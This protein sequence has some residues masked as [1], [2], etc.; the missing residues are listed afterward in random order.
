MAAG[1]ATLKV[2]DRE[3]AWA[4]LEERGA[5]LEAELKPVLKA[6]PFPASFVRVGSIG[7]FAL[8][9]G[10]PRSAEALDSGTGA[11]FK[12]IFQALLDRGIA[13]APSAFEVLFL[14]LAHKPE[15]ITRFAQAVGEVI[16][17]G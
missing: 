3:N 5:Q 15:E 4:R 14:S 6:A 1:L 9:A 12:T 13:I 2:L 16:T 11:R 8:Q 10:M 7:W 17:K